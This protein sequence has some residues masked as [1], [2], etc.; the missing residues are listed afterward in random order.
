MGDRPTG[1]GGIKARRNTPVNLPSE[2]TVLISSLSKVSAMGS[3]AKRIHVRSSCVCKRNC[4]PERVV[5]SVNVDLNM[6]I[7]SEGE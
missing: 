4:T 3:D 7:D 6:R 2:L 5:S 1:V